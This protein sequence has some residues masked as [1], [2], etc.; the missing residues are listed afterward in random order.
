MKISEV[1]ESL[2]PNGYLDYD[3]FKATRPKS[4]GERTRRG[5]GNLP[6]LCTDLFALAAVLLQRSGA[7]HHV[8]PESKAANVARALGVTKSMRAHWATLGTEWRA[9]GKGRG[10]PPPTGLV[11][12]WERFWACHEESIYAS[13]SPS[14]TAPAWWHPALAL[15]C[16]ADEA[17]RGMGFEPPEMA[18]AS[19]QARLLEVAL[20]RQI[21]ADE[22]RFSFSTADPDLVC[23]LPKSRTPMLGCTLRSLSHNLALLPPRGLARAYWL[24]SAGRH[25]VSEGGIGTPKPLNCLLVPMPFRIG[26]RD[27]GAVRSDEERWGWFQLHPSWCPS[28]DRVT[29]EGFQGFWEFIHDLI[30]AAENDVGQVHV[31]VFPETAISHAVFRLLTDRLRQTNV[32]LLV[33]GLFDIKRSEHEPCVHG[34]YAALAAIGE[35][36]LTSYRQKHHRWKLDRSQIRTYSL[37]SA[38]DPNFGWWEDLDILSRSL[39]V[40]VLRGTST[41]TTLICEDLARHDPCQ[42]LVRG[43][44]PN[45]VFALLM[46]GP[47]LK[48]RWPARY[49]TVLAEDPGSSVLSFTSLG[50]IER[51]N[52]SGL[53][54]ICRSVGLWRDDRGETI[55]L[56]IPSG[57][58]ALCLSLHSTDFEGHTLDGRGDG[59]VSESWRL[60]GVQPVKLANDSKHANE[61][62]NGRW[63]GS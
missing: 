39:D 29:Q 51:S 36:G 28:S 34:N 59:K 31:L 60:T 25:S 58:Q 33:A 14:Q 20:Q 19:F 56:S 54:P 30:Q 49:A 10:Q 47:Q 27:F 42:E 11:E 2:F 7:Y 50:L 43:I 21:I 38:L 40:Y 61:I 63:P 15:M 24:P 32:E 13:L 5:R 12:I 48:A 45:L 37:G 1:V 9:D 3:S 26:A 52:A 35:N 22:A 23:V 17:A 41:A 16:I 57:A 18:R 6:Y 44:G 55:E 46:D 4:D 8:A 62:M 53:Q